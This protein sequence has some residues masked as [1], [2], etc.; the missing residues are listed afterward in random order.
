MTM[1]MGTRPVPIYSSR[2]ALVPVLIVTEATN[3]FYY[4][5]I[6]VTNCSN[7]IPVLSLRPLPGLEKKRN[8]L[9]MIYNSREPIA[10]PLCRSLKTFY[11][12]VSG[13]KTP[14]ILKRYQITQ[15]TFA[16]TCSPP[17]SF[18]YPPITYRPLER[19]IV[20]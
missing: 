6:S 18:V 20:K 16:G 8:D 11:I 1:V 17:L 13:N 7:S 2:N 12:P 4:H 9:A 5:L 19:R 10:Q 14:S 3:S 15:A